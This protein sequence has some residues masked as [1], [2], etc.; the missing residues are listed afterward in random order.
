MENLIELL[1]SY[2]VADAEHRGVAVQQIHHGRNGEERV[3]L[4]DKVRVAE[5][6]SRL[7]DISALS[8][9]LEASVS[10]PC[11]TEDELDSM[12]ELM[13]RYRKRVFGK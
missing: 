4:V 6:L 10:R 11:E 5:L 12:L 7:L 3:E 1:W 13:K 8:P 9:S 2:L